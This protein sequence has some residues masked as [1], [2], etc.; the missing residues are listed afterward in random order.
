MPRENRSTACFWQWCWWYS[1]AKGSPPS[2]RTRT[3]YGQPMHYT[4]SKIFQESVVLLC[5]PL[6]PPL[7]TRGPDLCAAFTDSAGSWGQEECNRE[8][9]QARVPKTCVEVRKRREYY[10]HARLN[11]IS[12]S[13]WTG[14][15]VGSVHAQ[16]P[17]R[18]SPLKST[19]PSRAIEVLKRDV[20][21]PRYFH[22]PCSLA[23]TVHAAP[24]YHPDRNPSKDAET[25]FIRIAAAYE[26]LDD[27]QRRKQY[28]SNPNQE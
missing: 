20:L 24:R 26:L 14:P 17:F 10:C 5:A 16:P 3:R 18:E 7:S 25:Q 8:R 22:T 4:Y 19:F 28:D 27:K 13:L 6:S 21:T 15:T 23:R 12:I 2:T 1:T 11:Y 9:N